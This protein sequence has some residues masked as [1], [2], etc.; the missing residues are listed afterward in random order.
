MKNNLKLAHALTAC[1]LIMPLSGI[2]Q[3][4]EK[5]LAPTKTN[6]SVA[7]VDRII[8][9]VNNE[10]ITQNELQER[11]N[12]VLKQMQKAGTTPPAAE[13]FTKQLLERQINEMVQLLEAKESGVRIDDATLEASIKNYA[14]GSN[15]SMSEFRELIERDGLKWSKFRED[16]RNDLMVMRIRERE[17]EANINIT[18]A[19]VD[20][21]LALESKEANSD[22]EFRL[23]HILVV[24]PEQATSDQIEVKRKKAMQALSELR[25]GSEFAQV[26]AQYS[27]AP[28]ALQGG[29]LGWRPAGRLP[30]IFLES[31]NTLKQGEIT[32]ILRSPNGF[33]IVKLL[34]KRGV[35]AA[36][37]ITQTNTRHILIRNKE[38]LTDD[39]AKSRLARL[40]ERITT[41]A[42]FAELAKVHSD[43]ASAAKGGDLGWLAPGAAVPEFERVMT[44]LRDNEV[45]QPIQTPFGWHLVQVLARRTEG[46]SNDR[47]R[48]TARGVIRQRK[49][50]EAYQDWV[51]QIRDRAFVE[52][53]L[54]EK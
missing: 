30:A 52:Y 36:P 32:D 45:S 1:L 8:A 18:D 47:K 29:N 23:A 7:V 9:V 41:G 26:S 53:R 6:L 44:Q 25:R 54:D 37:T 38:G 3:K 17:V 39:E 34:D 15:V 42:D 43:D 19:E 49:G 12:V 50:D 24:V 4:L 48:E 10:V 27:D 21:Q 33:H 16:V 22:K 46:V 35:S 13:V 14:D 51:R 28:D 11:M 31:L 5:T 40:R 2:A 20:T